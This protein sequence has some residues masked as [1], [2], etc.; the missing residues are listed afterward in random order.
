M[1]TLRLKLNNI[2]D[3]YIYWTKILLYV[4]FKAAILIEPKNNDD[5]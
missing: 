4:L 3:K 2:E 5:Q 1:T